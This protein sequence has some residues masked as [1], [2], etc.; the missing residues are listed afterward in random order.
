MQVVL[1]YPGRTPTGLT[2]E[3]GFGGTAVGPEEAVAEG[4]PAGRS[5]Q[6]HRLVLSLRKAVE[7]H[8]STRRT[9]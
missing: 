9:S 5:F 6:Y 1:R 8:S 3:A 2:E 7:V 4:A